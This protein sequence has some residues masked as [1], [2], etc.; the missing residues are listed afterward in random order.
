MSRAPTK[1]P[2]LAPVSIIAR[3]PIR[4][5]RFNFLEFLT[6]VAGWA[7]AVGMLAWVHSHPVPAR[8]QQLLAQTLLA[9]L[10]AGLLYRA[11]SHPYFAQRF[12]GVAT[13][14]DL[15]TVRA[16]SCFVLAAMAY[17]E[18]I[19]AASSLPASNRYSVGVMDWLYASPLGFN[20]LAEHHVALLALKISTVVVLLVASAGYRTRLTLPLGALLYL[21]LGG[22]VRSYLSFT[23][24]GIIPFFVVM[25][26]CFTPCADGFSIDRLRRRRRQLPV[27]PNDEASAI[28]AWSRFA[29]WCTLAT[30]YVMA[31]MNKLRFGGWMWWDGVN[32]QSMVFK[33]QFKP[34]AD[35]FI[36][37]EQWQWAPAWAFS[38]I[39]IYTLVTEIGMGLTPFSRR[40]RR[41]W[42]FLAIVMH[43]GI[44]LLQTIA[45]WDLIALQAIFFDWSGLRRWLARKQIVQRLLAA[46][47][48]P[49]KYPRQNSWFGPARLTAAVSVL[50]TTWA[51][52]VEFYPLTSIAMY[53]HR[54]SSGIL[55]YYWIVQ[56]DANG[57]TRPADLAALT[58]ESRV[59]HIPL[60][61]AFGSRDERRKCLELLRYCGE[62]W[63]RTAGADERV[64]HIE[65]QRREWDYVNH[66]F[67]P[68]HGQVVERMGVDF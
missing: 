17:C 9:I 23:H 4:A 38:C 25:V 18:Q 40:A 13:A 56:T 29:V 44:R 54:Y 3:G 7:L 8:W 31:G 65:I 42:P 32:L 34:Y 37:V 49:V 55:S 50:L 59:F 12:V 27:V 28:Y 33:T 36:H 11:V 63:N 2:L 20:W 66:R 51:L 35:S 68:D 24:N 16:I 46:H 30:A 64:K 62:Q 67:D 6:A 53:S 57:V 15:G 60:W 1:V 39:G 47:H 10:S 58:P 26:L 5:G 45:F 14:A 41:V 61:H 48:S 21:L 52:H 43:I 22:I 19:G